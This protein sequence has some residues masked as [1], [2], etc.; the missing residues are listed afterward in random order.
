[1]RKLAKN[2]YVKENGSEE[3]IQYHKNFAIRLLE[4]ADEVYNPPMPTI[5]TTDT[6]VNEV[7]SQIKEWVHQ[8]A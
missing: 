7:A 3:E 1:M 2:V 5:D 8:Y 4:I 6:D